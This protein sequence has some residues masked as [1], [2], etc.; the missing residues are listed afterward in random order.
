MTATIGADPEFF[1]SYYNDDSGNEGTIPCVGIIE[2]TKEEPFS[3][4]DGFF[5]HEDN[6]AVELGIPPQTTQGG[7]ADAI[8]HGKEMI[9]QLL[10]E[11]HGGPSHYLDCMAEY[12]FHPDDLQSEQA[13]HFG[14]E[15]DYNAYETGK[16]RTMPR[17]TKL[18]NYRHAGGHIHIGGEFKCPPFVAA[19]FADCYLYLWPALSYPEAR[20]ASTLDTERRS[21]WY[22]RPGVFRPKPYGIEYRTPSNWW[23]ENR[24]KAQMMGR[25]AL[26]LS[27]FL[28][29]TSSTALREMVRSIR[30]LDVQRLVETLRTFGGQDQWIGEVSAVLDDLRRVGVPI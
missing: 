11:N 5:T 8:M 24:G 14:C 18:S 30:W 2:G 1:V 28:E 12:S 16:M 26:R 10:D 27:R 4:G 13:K 29:G 3:L 23:C 19:L 15:P 17:A 22:G 6:V 9:I 21:Q 25:Q 20:P 7:F